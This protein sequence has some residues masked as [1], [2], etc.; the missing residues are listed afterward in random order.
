[1]GYNKTFRAP[2]LYKNNKK[3][4]SKHESQGDYRDGDL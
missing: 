1:M 2:P 3:R 4:R